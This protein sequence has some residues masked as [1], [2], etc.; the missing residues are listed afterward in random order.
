MMESDEQL[1]LISSPLARLTRLYTRKLFSGLVKQAP[2]ICHSTSLY[3]FVE[4]FTSWNNHMA[5]HLKRRSC[6]LLGTVTV[7][8]ITPR[9]RDVGYVKTPGF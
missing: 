5:T 6:S 3:E 7:S 8:N 2:D 1:S 9:K 4:S